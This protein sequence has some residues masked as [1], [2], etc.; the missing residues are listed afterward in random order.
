MIAGFLLLNAIGR[1]FALY[2]AFGSNSLPEIGGLIA[3]IA[4]YIAPAYGIIKLKKWAR[5]FEIG[6]SIVMVVAGIITAV[7]ANI[8][9]GAIIIITHGLVAKYLM[10]AKIKSLFEQAS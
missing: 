7:A 10:S 3:A 5:I 9:Q 8:L 1:I 6:F 4:L 2:E